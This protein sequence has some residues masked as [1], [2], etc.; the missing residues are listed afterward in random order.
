MFRSLMIHVLIS[1]FKTF[2][3]INMLYCNYASLS[4]T[5]KLINSKIAFVLHFKSS[6]VSLELPTFL[7]RKKPSTLT[8]QLCFR[9]SKITLFRRNIVLPAEKSLASLCCCNCC[10]TGLFY[11]KRVSWQELRFKT[12]QNLSNYS[13]LGFSYV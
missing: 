9:D 8:G 4:S 12:E 7:K 13:V 3:F 10:L 11:Y 5:T 2:S 1:L 6:S